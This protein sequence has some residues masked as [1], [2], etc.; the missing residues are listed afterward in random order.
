MKNF[1]SNLNDRMNP[2]MIKEIRQFSHNRFFLSLTI[3]LLGFQ[4]LMLLIFFMLRRERPS[5]YEGGNIFLIID[6]ILM[7]LCIFFSAASAMQRFCAERTSHDLDFTSVTLLTPFQIV[8][9]KLASSLITAL[10]IA[11]LCMPLMAVVYFYR[12]VSFSDISQI[13]IAGT[14]PTLTLIQSA[15]FCGALG[16]KWAQGLF[17]YFCFQVVFPVVLAAAAVLSRPSGD[18][19]Q[20]FWM[21]QGGVLLL[22]AILFASTAA[23]ITPPFANRMLPV[24]VLLFF[25]LL[26]LFG[27]I[28]FMSKQSQDA[29][30][31]F[32]SIPLGLLGIAGI[33]VLCDREQTGPRI[34]SQV[35]RN[36]CGRCFHFLLS[37]NRSGAMA[38]LILMLILFAAAMLTTHLLGQKKS[39]TMIAFAFSCYLV[40]YTEIA[41]CIHRVIHHIPGFVIL[42]FT[43][44]ILGAVP[45][46]F[47]NGTSI[48]HKDI[49]FSPF[50]I[51]TGTG[52]PEILDQD[53][54]MPF[55]LAMI[56][57]IYFLIAG[58][59]KF[60]QW[61]APEKT[62]TYHFPE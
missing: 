12:A 33:L 5:G 50:W 61:H 11:V 54:W 15:L 49:F 42:L 9:G 62:V 47:V 36:F 41:L 34:L 55:L 21:L 18:A 60:R 56:P 13:F 3:G 35:P 1:I 51:M 45:A 8:T 28:P 26:I 29:A 24:R 32:S 40:F 20:I 6:S 30:A 19:M 7:Y 52:T 10:L 25:T 23:L 37:S 53:F 57:G 4:L 16:K 43:A 22:W 27:F 48:T 59:V 58:A 14:F 39:L 31:T 17:L 2:V 38:G 46:F 44:A